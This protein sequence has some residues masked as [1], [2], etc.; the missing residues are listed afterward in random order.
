MHSLQNDVADILYP[1][2]TP[3]L[4]TAAAEKFVFADSLFPDSTPSYCRL[5]F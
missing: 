1:L 5:N 3:H 4:V 2:E